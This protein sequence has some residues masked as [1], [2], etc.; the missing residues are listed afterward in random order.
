[1]ARLL[2][3]GFLAPEPARGFAHSFLQQFD[4]RFSTVEIRPLRSN[5]DFF[6]FHSHLKKFETGRRMSEM[7]ICNNTV[8]PP[9]AS[10]SR[11][12]YHS[13]SSHGPRNASPH[14]SPV[15]VKFTDKPQSRQLL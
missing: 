11:T 12:A 13:L 15:M 5:F 2:R 1:M 6:R 7:R 3:D 8:Q 4:G 9:D 14:I 10:C